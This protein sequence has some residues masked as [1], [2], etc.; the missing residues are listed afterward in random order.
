LK[1]RR[2][3]IGTV[4]EFDDL[5]GLAIFVRI[6]EAGSISAA[7][8]SMGLPKATMSRG[9]VALEKRLDTQLILRST[10]ALRLT[11]A[12]RRFFEQVQPLVHAAHAAS[13]ELQGQSGKHSGLLR[14][15]ASVAYG[16]AEV[17]PRLLTFMQRHPE[18]RIELHL[19][20]D[21]VSVVG[22]SYDLA[23]RMGR[24]A[25][26]E[27]VSRKLADIPMVIVAA[28]SW[29]RVHGV[30]RAPAELAVHSAVVTRPDLLHWNIGGK[31][32]RARWRMSTGNMLVTRDAVRAGL[33]IGLMP[34]FLAADCL[35]AGRLVR[36]LP[37]LAIPST[38]ATALYA[39]SGTRSATVKALI[40]VLARPHP[41]AIG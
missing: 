31:T 33:G 3:R 10:R 11:D 18:V 35:A 25:N 37:E 15:A 28:P 20:D 34:E 16:Q 39:K 36:L 9:L 2:S 13:A 21:R 30:P 32:V 23:I 19:H 14:V 8:R 5:S 24:I 12:G 17:A 7:G 1:R 6:V 4:N 27:L 40:E 22:E 41:L 29:I 26:C 38:Q